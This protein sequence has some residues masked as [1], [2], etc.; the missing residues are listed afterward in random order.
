MDAG[1]VNRLLK[2]INNFGGI[3]DVNQLDG[4][5]IFSLPVALV[6]NT[7][8]HWISVYLDNDYLEIMDSSGEICSDS[9]NMILC[10][11]LCTHSIG[12]TFI[13]SPQLQ[14]DNSSDCGLY[15]VAFLYFRILTGQSL[16]VFLKVF[17]KNF[18]KNSKIIKKIFVSITALN[19]QLSS[20]D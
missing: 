10:R 1:A 15:A 3:F 12:K 13:S 18:H 5:K 16:K 17:G 14:A 6:I 20:I 2:N 8:D 7:S 19:K 11:F 9:V 4:V